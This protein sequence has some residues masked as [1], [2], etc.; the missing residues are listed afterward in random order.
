MKNKVVARVA[1]SPTGLMHIGTARV[2]LFNYLFVKQNKGK[3]ILRIEDTDR[4]RYKPEFEKNIKDGYDWL[5]L[6]FDEVWKQSERTDVYSQYLNK[7]LDQGLAYWSQEE[8]K[9]EGDRSSVIRFKNPGQ[10]ITFQDLIHGEITFDTTELGDFVI[11]KDTETAI[12]HFANVVD[13]LDAG[14]THII[15][16]DDHISNTPRQILLFR[17]LGAEVPLY[18]HLPMILTSDKSKLSKRHG[19]WPITEYQAEG[20]LK[21]AVL[22]FIV[23]LGWSPQSCADIV[24]DGLEDVLTLDQMIEF[25]DLT[26]VQKKGAIFNLEKLNWLNREHLKKYPPAEQAAKLAEWI[27]SA[28]TEMINAH[29]ALLPKITPLILERVS[30]FKEAQALLADGEFDYFFIQPKPSLALLRDTTNLAETASLLEQIESNNFTAETVKNKIWDFATKRGRGAV[31]WPLRVALTGREKSPD[32]FIVA[33]ILGQ[34][35]TLVRIKNV[36]T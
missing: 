28:K 17:A 4:Q 12:F 16:G 20:Y 14:V 30:T 25:F 1:P 13:D 35:E 26:K 11:A 29:K 22:N 15:R 8:I 21:E 32:P 24:Q 36:I 33:E 23:L 34:A 6:S 5:G 31:L 18:A 2:A 9:K 7:L 19:A 27:P 10:K 3:L